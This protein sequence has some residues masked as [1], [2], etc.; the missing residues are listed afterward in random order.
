MNRVLVTGGSGFIGTNYLK[1][2][3]KKD[4]KIKATYYEN[5]NFYKVENVEYV[6]SNLENLSECKEICKNIDIVI[7]C[8]ANSSGAA[9]MERTPLVHLT[10]NIRMN[11]NMLEAAYEAGIK[12]FVFISSNTVY[13]HVDYAVKENDTNYK[14]FEKYHVVGWMKKFTEEVCEIYSNKIKNKMTTIV[15]RPGN[16]YG[17]H[18]KFDEEKSKVIASLIR[19]IVEKQDPIIVWGDGNDL[20]DFLYI[21][22]FVRALDKIVENINNY[23]VLN[24]ASGK[25]ITIKEIL[26]KIITIESAEYLNIKFDSTK[27][28]MIPKRLIDISKSK[29]IINFE[30]SIN[31]QDGL[32]KTID[33]YKKNFVK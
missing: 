3:N 14:F 6:K 18:D 19:K 22:D 23:Q 21:E 20:K 28:T 24:I 7:M 2:V 31:M 12:K 8:A 9:I 29:E 13:P 1:F 5:E 16:L 30:P 33:W 17:P 26:K 25:G 32:R 15:I 11:L 4:Y 10:P 27:P